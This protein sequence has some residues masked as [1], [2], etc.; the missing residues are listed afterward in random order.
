VAE[1][2]NAGRVHAGEVVLDIGDGVGALIIYTVPALEGV[3]IEVS[4]GQA[5]PRVHTEVL[6]RRIGGQPVFAAVYASLPEG[7]YHIWGFEDRLQSEVDVRSGQ[8]AEV[9]WR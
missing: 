3:E 6:E 5:A 8:V 1:Q 4:R 2:S 9:D 7:R